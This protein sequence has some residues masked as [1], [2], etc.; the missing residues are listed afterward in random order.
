VLVAHRADGSLRVAEDEAYYW[1]WSQHLAW[2]FFDH[3]PAIAA[4]IRMGTA[5]LGGTERVFTRPVLESCRSHT[6]LRRSRD[7]ILAIAVLGAMPL[8]SVA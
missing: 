2:G 3:P 8:R 1:V 6:S 5:V 7:R 4:I